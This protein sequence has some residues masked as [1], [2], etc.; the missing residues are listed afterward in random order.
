MI[1]PHAGRL[2]GGY[3]PLWQSKK[4]PLR[5]RKCNGSF[6]SWLMFI[7]C[8]SSI[9]MKRF[10]ACGRDQRA[11]R[12][13]SGLLRV[14]SYQL[15]LNQPDQAVM[16]LRNSNHPPSIPNLSSMRRVC[17]APLRPSWTPTEGKSRGVEDPFGQGV[18]RGRRPRGWGAGAKPLVAEG[19]TPGLRFSTCGLDLGRRR[20]FG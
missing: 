1:S 5:L 7:K 8:T 9:P 15:E 10:R 2:F 20:L 6:C 17:H 16:N 13:P 12:S 4:E 18:Q 11:L 14:P 19:E 3:G